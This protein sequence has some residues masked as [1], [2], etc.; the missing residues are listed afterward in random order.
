MEEEELC[1]NLSVFVVSRLFK[2]EVIKI[3]CDGAFFITHQDI[4][5]HT[6]DVCAYPLFLDSVLKE[7]EM[8][9]VELVE[10]V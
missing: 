8:N 10:S 9:G 1:Q 2:K 3:K 7:L 4:Y 6:L 5:D